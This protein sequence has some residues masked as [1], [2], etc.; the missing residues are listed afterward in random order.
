M[1]LHPGGGGQCPKIG[2]SEFP[3]SLRFSV[4]YIALL[5]FG[6]SQACLAH[7]IEIER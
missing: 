1:V 2:G 3:I 7:E 4:R 6:V 5:Q